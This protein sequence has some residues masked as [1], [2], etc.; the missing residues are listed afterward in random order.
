[1][2]LCIIA[3]FGYKKTVGK[4][5]NRG[6]LGRVNIKTVGLCPTP[7]KLFEKSLTKNFKSKTAHMRGFGF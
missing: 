2:F 7:H 5:K 6:A 1:V 3:S 4:D